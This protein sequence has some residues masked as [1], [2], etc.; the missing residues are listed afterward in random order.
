MADMNLHPVSVQEALE[1]AEKVILMPVEGELSLGH[2]SALTEHLEHS[3]SC[4]IAVIEQLQSAEAGIAQYMQVN[5]EL[6]AV[7]TAILANPPAT[8]LPRPTE[9]KRMYD[10]DIDTWFTLD[11][12]GN[13][14]AEAFPDVIEVE[15]PDDE[16]TPCGPIDCPPVTTVEF[17][18][19]AATMK[20]HQSE[21]IQGLAKE[22]TAEFGG[23]FD[24]GCKDCRK[25]QRIGRK[26]CP[27]HIPLG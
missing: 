6:T 5:E 10:Q 1:Y 24:P 25:F 11:A 20:M 27:A 26:A 16:W 15:L 19:D 2:L 7:M 3:V 17:R 13:W 14:Q 8:S 21:I 12:T 9:P 18:T 4:L 22:I 23:Q